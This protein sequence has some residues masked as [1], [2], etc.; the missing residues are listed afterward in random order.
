MRVREGRLEAHKPAIITPEA[1][2]DGAA[3]GFGEQARA[4]LEFLKQHEDSI[5][6]LQYGYKLSQEAF[7]EQVVTDSMEAVTA[8]VVADVVERNEVFGAV[9]QGVDDPWDVALVELW[10]REV[11]RRAGKNIRELGEKG[12]LF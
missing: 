3:E 4:Y 8:R 7:S 10:R 11:E 12:K 1:Y 9:I 5:R 2:M 6:I